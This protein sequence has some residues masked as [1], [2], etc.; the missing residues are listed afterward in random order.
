MKRISRQ[1]AALLLAIVMV[2]G[3]TAAPVFAAET[4]IFDDVPKNA[5]YR[6]YVMMLA[7]KEIVKG[8]S[9]T[10]EFRP[11]NKLTRE[12]AAKMI[13]LAA[14]LDHEG[15]KADFPDVNE[16]G[17]ASP[18][19]AALQIKDALKGFPDS[20]FRPFDNIKRGH[21]AKIVALAFDLEE[22]D[23]VGTLTDLPEDPDV[24]PNIEIL[25]SNGIV[26]GYGETKCFRP[27]DQISRAEFSKILC[28]SMAVAALQ[29]AEADPTPENL[30]AAQALIDELPEDQDEDTRTYLQGRADAVE[31]EEEPTEVIVGKL[32]H[33]YYAAGETLEFT[34][35][36][37]R[38][39]T[40]IRVGM[41][42]RTGV[43]WGWESGQHVLTTNMRDEGDGL[44]WFGTTDGDGVLTVS[45]IV[46]PNLP[47]GVLYITLP[48]YGYYIDSA[49]ELQ[50]NQGVGVRVGDQQ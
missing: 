6:G 39:N 10:K 48:D 18:Y 3:F 43:G 37:L 36:G 13:S 28:I 21:A 40:E 32:A 9:D 14:G 45:G 16:D 49:M 5:W 25:E 30:A 31:A 29:E 46:G 34:I 50:D 42:I 12:Q 35:S 44:Y 47:D 38:P 33:N 26:K 7:E 23:L 22:G 19:I 1:L 8:F 20:N 24:K 11:D 15:L 41:P 4:Q 17:W 2:L 27:E